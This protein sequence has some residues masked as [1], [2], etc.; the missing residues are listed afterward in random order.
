MA[1]GEGGNR[2][3]WS[4]RAGFVLAAI[5]SAVGIGNIWRFSSVVGQN[6]GGAYLVPYLV[7]VFLFAYPLMLLEFGMGRHF[8]KTVVGAFGSVGPRLRLAGWFLAATIFLVLCYYL[9][10]TGWTVA[11]AAFSLAGTPVT[12]RAFT[13]SY[14]PVASFLFS[15]AVTVAIVSSRSAS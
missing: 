15:A 5:G 10:I 9:V 2:E 8:A 4:S 11:Y 13:G 12:F 14:L 3:S 7:A 1:N 6:G